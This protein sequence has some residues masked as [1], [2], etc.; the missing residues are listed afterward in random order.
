MGEPP[1]AGAD[2]DTTDLLSAY[3]VADTLKGTAGG[4][5]ATIELDDPDDGP[6]PEPLVAVT[7]KL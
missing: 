3:E 6:V 2:H 1:L 4:P 5:V 7:R